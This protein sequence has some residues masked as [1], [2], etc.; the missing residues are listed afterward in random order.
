MAEA[1]YKKDY[2]NTTLKNTDPKTIQ[3]H[4]YDILKNNP[5]YLLHHQILNTISN[6]LSNVCLMYCHFLCFS[7]FFFFF[8]F[9]DHICG[10]WRLPG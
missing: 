8:F 2:L 1:K 7:F 10:I 9:L 4:E 5:Q 3:H 6:V